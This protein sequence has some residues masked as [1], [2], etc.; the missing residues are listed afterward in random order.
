MKLMVVLN[1]KMFSASGP[2]LKD[3]MEYSSN[4][5]KKKLV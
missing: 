3:D 4:L 1:L 2:R 5:N